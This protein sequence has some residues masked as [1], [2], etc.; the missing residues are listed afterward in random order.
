MTF[1][2]PS[3]T[4]INTAAPDAEAQFAAAEPALAQGLLDLRRELLAQPELA[5][6]VRRKYSIRNT[7]GLRLLAL[8]DG[9]TPLQIFRRLMVGSEGVLGFIA[10]AVFQTVLAANETSVAWLPFASID[11]AIAVVPDL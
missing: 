9:E 11:D 3:G 6:R 10:E 5:E 7:H 2:L 8:L 1:V 4:T